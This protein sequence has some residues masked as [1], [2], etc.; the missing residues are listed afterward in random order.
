MKTITIRIKDQMASQLAEIDY[1][2]TT[3]GQIA[4]ELFN[5]IRRATIIELKGIFSREEI[6]VMTDCFNTLIPTWR[7]LTNQEIF[8][9][10]IIDGQHFDGVC[11]RHNADFDALTRKIRALSSAQVAVLHL[12][13]YRFWNVEGD[14]GY[15]APSPDMEKLIDFLT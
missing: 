3:A 2:P 6:I 7:Y 13:L 12:E 4:I 10:E 1:R 14:K 9:A 8:L 5:S 15:G 11:D